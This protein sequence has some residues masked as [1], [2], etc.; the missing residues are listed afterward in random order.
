MTDEESFKLYCFRLLGR[1]EYSEYEITT[2][3]LKKGY[4]EEVITTVINELQE[5][6]YQ[7][8][9]RCAEAI[10]NQYKDT[11]GLRWIQQKC[12][13]RRIDSSLLNALSQHYSPQLGQLK[14]TIKR[15][16][17]LTSFKNMDYKLYGKISGYL[18]RRGFSG[19]TLKEWIALDEGY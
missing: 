3:G 15:K 18:Q 7:S 13:M 2:K 12:N 4:T 1:R 16:Y 8:D 14:E 17:H 5:Q 10:W 6:N 19:Q 11:K 9:Q